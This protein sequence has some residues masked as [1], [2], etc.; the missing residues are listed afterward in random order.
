MAIVGLYQEAFRGAWPH[1]VAHG[2]T[3]RQQHS[4]CE[5]FVCWGV[6]I[7]LSGQAILLIENGGFVAHSTRN[8]G[9]GGSGRRLRCASTYPTAPSNLSSEVKLAFQS[10]YFSYNWQNTDKRKG[11]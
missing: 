4:D 10:K 6:R 7:I 5:G 3:V 8:G 9:F 2:V 11:L 1:K